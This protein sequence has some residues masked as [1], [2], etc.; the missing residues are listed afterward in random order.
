MQG[1]FSN[2]AR[3]SAEAQEVLVAAPRLGS[4]PKE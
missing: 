2:T 1:G 3:A 4:R